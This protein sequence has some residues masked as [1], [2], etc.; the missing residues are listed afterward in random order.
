[1]NHFKHES[2]WKHFLSLVESRLEEGAK[3]YGDKSFFRH[4]S[5]ISGEIEQELLDIVGWSFILWLRITKGRSGPNGNQKI[6]P[7]RQLDYG[8]FAKEFKKALWPAGKQ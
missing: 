7:D 3:V 2:E 8:T 4:P 5:E 1:M 6:D